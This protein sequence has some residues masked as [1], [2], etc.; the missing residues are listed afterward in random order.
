M[1]ATFLAGQL[2][3]AMPGIGDPRFERAVV[4]LCAHDAEH[5]LGIA[6]NRPIDGLTL[7][8]LFDKLDIPGRGPAVADP[9]L[10]GGPLETER[11]FVLHTDD[12]HGAH[13]VEAG[14]GLSLT[15]T[16]EVLQAMAMHEA[17]P[18]KAILALGYA[19]WGANQ[20]EA[21][22]KEN[23]WLTCEADEALIFDDDHETKW[24]RALSKL[25]INPERLSYVAGRA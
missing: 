21:E 6:V 20:L 13:S 14:D 8:E 9:V 25:G 17:A 12:Y 7:G 19:G 4:L 1:D 11:G 2:L 23:V 10:I 22:L 16:R 24:V 15:A 3:I 18:R 5:A